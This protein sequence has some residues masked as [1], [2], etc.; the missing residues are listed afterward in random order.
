M[1]K[2]GQEIYSKTLKNKLKNLFEV[3]FCKGSYYIHSHRRILRKTED[4]SEPTVWW[5]KKKI[6]DFD[7]RN[8][9]IRATRDQS[10]IIIN[11]NDTR[12]VVVE[13]KDD[14]TAGREIIIK[15]ETSSRISC[16][17]ALSETRILTVNQKGLIVI[18]E[19]DFKNYSGSKEIARHQ[20]KV[21]PERNENCFYLSVCDRSKRVAVLIMKHGYCVKASRIQMYELN[22]KGDS[23]EEEKIELKAEIDIGSKDLECYYS[24][25]ISQYIGDKLVIFGY[26]YKNT[27]VHT[28]YYDISSAELI[29]RESKSLFAEHNKCYKLQRYGN[30]VYGILWGG[31]I[32]KI[33]FYQ[34]I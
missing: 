2:E 4:S 8:K 20:I 13:V 26:S 27:S 7:Y 23:G 3:V 22:T 16:H 21:N 12:L 10:A 28:Y 31:K 25:C 30:Q 29:E 24:I 1:R 18:Y 14:G 17:E 33:N 15:N 11:V 5:D 32:V 19:V 6:S 34:L 9:N